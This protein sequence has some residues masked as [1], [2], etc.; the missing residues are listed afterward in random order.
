MISYIFYVCIVLFLTYVGYFA[1]EKFR[2][3]KKFYISWLKFHQTF[4][5][6]I[7]YTRRPVQEIVKRFSEEKESDFEAFLREYEKK[8]EWK[9]KIDCLNTEEN[10]FLKEYFSFLGRSDYNA[11]KEYFDSVTKKLE[12]MQK[13]SEIKAARYTDLYVKLGFLLGLAIVILLA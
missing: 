11:Q 7:C 12:G 4:L 9:G 6:E 5:Y 2:D 1:S 10:E 8:H 3:S 13:E